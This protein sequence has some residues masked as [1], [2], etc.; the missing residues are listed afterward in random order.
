MI[1]TIVALNALH[2]A[3]ILHWAIPSSGNRGSCPLTPVGQLSGKATRRKLANAHRIPQD[4]HGFR[5]RK[6][7]NLKFFRFSCIH[8]ASGRELTSDRADP[9]N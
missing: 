9:W 5:G 2:I 7:A 1:V 8:Q 3:T 4:L 6:T